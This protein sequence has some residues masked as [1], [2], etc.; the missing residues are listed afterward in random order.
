M[1]K[2]Y[3][4]SMVFGLAALALAS[5]SDPGD[6][7][8]EIAY[9]RN[10]SPTSFEANVRNR[11]NVEL[12]WKLAEGV[13]QYNVEVYAND[14]LTFAGTPV[15]TFSVTP[16]K[17]PVLITGLDG[18]TQYSFRVQAVDDT[19]GR[20]SKWSGAYAKTEAEQIF[21]NVA[22]EDIN[23]SSVTLR[24]SAGEEAAIITLNPGNWPPS[25]GLA[26]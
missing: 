5:C 17:V 15:K 2:I 8:T 7:I 6:E 14:S 16:D 11:T 9:S 22:E 10:F 21:K 25:P 13:K 4:K 12:R 23:G 19:P 18:E 26:P 1:K 24:W 3:L 20:D